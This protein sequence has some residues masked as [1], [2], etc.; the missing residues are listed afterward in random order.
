VSVLTILELK[1][2]VAALLGA[3]LALLGQ[4]VVRR[5]ARASTARRLAVAFWEELSAANFYG[6][7]TNPNFAGFSSQTFD[8]LFRDMADA[9]PGSLVRDLM[10]Y[11]W[12][13]K[14]LEE[15]KSI[16]IPS[17]GGVNPQFW[18]EASD[19]RDQLLHRLD[20]YAKRRG[21]FLSLAERT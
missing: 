4:W 2:V 10:R 19:L 1:Q 11:H 8:S 13:M 15:T 9:L 20:R 3:I 17:F 16:S 6:P 12:R 14:Y 5:G 21:L 18:R 7:A